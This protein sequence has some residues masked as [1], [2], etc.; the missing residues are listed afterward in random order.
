MENTVVNI[1]KNT[2]N[3]GFSCDILEYLILIW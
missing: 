3:T 1:K 2:K